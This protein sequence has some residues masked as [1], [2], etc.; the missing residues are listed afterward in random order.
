[1]RSISSAAAL[2]IFAVTAIFPGA[3]LGQSS[4]SG[5]APGAAELV[6]AP[7]P[8]DSV[9]ARPART[10]TFHD[11]VYET[12]GPFPLAS[13]AFMAGIHQ[14]TRN[15]PEWREGFPGYGERFASGLGISSIDVTTRY[16]LAVALREDTLYYRCRCSG[17]WPRLRHVVLESA[18][19]RRGPD[20]HKVFSLPVFVAPYAGPMV[21]VYTWYPNRYD[22]KDAFR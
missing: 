14:A 5:D 20:G 10:D 18:V 19:A 21:A 12:F 3:A 4:G 1:M 15:P 16:S 2:L 6:N 22:W 7:A 13:A 8:A 17:V 9:Y 11:Y